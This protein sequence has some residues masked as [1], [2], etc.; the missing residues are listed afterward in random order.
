[1]QAR[2]QIDLRD[3]V[4]SMLGTDFLPCSI[5]A[6]EKWISPLAADMSVAW[7]ADVDIVF[8]SATMNNGCHGV[9]FSIYSACI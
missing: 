1:M 5:R 3:E 9:T 8:L 2:Q 4:A 7:S 6:D